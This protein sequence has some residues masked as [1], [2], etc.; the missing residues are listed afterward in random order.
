M[1]ILAFDVSKDELVGVR[2]DKNGTVKDTFTVPNTHKDINAFFDFT[3]GQHGTFLMGSES[4]GEYHR[5]LALQ[6]VSRD[7]PFYLLNPILTKQFTRSTIR[8]K[9][10]D[11]SDAAIIARLLA[12]GEG[13][14]L[15]KETL[16]PIKQI[17]RTANSINTLKKSLL[18]MLLHLQGV[19]PEKTAI[20]AEIEAAGAGLEAVVECL[21]K[22]VQEETNPLLKK[23]LMSIP[24]IG[25]RVAATL[26][27][28]IGMI[29]KFKN[30]KRLVA[31]A[32][33]DPKVNQSGV[34]LHK[35]TRLTKRGSPYLRQ[36]IYMAAFIAVQ[37]DPELREYFEKK[38]K[39]GKCYREGVIATARKILYRVF[40][41]W[42]RGTPYVKRDSGSSGTKGKENIDKKLSP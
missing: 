26:I 8:K 14:L 1:T 2:A 3:K 4:T 18:S 28:E 21:R 32:G 17:N 22:H 16:N 15:F 42:K 29:Q 31:Y 6:A 23:L 11:K 12:Q 10:T 7:I 37:H 20:L 19:C 35:N 5:E 38:R 41:V 39:E 27:A 40:A 30:G 33:L 9:K 13:T 36:S 25:E 34:S 24:G